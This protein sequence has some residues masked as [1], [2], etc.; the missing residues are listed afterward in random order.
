MKNRN[1]TFGVILA[2]VACLALVPV[3]QAVSPA[4]DG[5]YPNY[6]TAEGCNALGGLTTGVGNTG[7]G[8]YSLFSVATNSFNTSVGAGA[9]ALNNADSNTAVGA[10]AMLLNTSGFENAA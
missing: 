8:W 5:C 6:T 4:P 3:T 9:L 7:V 10:T 1:K 2:A